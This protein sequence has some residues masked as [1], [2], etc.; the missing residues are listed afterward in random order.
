MCY[1]YGMTALA[2][3]LK[4]FIAAALLGLIVLPIKLLFVRFFP[5]GKVKTFLLRDLEKTD[6]R[7]DYS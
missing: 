6:R 7:G 3:V 2:L 4:P 5:D 1:K